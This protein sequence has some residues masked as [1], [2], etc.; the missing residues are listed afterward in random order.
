MIIRITPDKERAKS[1]IKMVEERESSIEILKKAN[2]PTIVGEA[3]YEIVKEL[4]TA[5]LLLE[6]LKT[7]GEHA[8]KELIEMMATYKEFDEW[9]IVFLDDLRV[10]RNK[11]D[12]EGKPFPA[13]YILHHKNTLKKIIS[14]LKK[15]IQSK[16]R[17]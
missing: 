6:G 7:V 1:I 9:E 16:L 17:G 15:A 2:F 10:I 13:D 11:S 14:K 4:A 3:Y 12:Y 8:H 5:R